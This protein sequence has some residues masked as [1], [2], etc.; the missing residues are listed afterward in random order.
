MGTQ[1]ILSSSKTPSPDHSCHVCP[2]EQGTT[3]VLQ[4]TNSD[5][6][7]VA[8]KSSLT[9]SFLTTYAQGSLGFE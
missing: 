8:K 2:R 1:K 5:F 7:V 4:M 9:S 6:Q 3:S